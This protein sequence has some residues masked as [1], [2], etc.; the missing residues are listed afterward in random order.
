M[1]FQQSRRTSDRCG[2]KY[3]GEQNSGEAADAV[4]AEHA[5]RAVAVETAL[6][7]GAAR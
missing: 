6:Q 5:E 3:A 7:P 4:N 2:G 1:T